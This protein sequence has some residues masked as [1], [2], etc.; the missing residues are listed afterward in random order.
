[1]NG[2]Q[3]ILNVHKPFFCHVHHF[4]SVHASTWNNTQHINVL[5]KGRK[6]DESNTSRVYFSDESKEY[7]RDYLDERTLRG[8]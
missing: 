6:Q 4:I 1:M 7:I 8:E 5:R 2:M 3:K